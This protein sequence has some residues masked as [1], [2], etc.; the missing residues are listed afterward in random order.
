MEKRRNDHLS[1]TNAQLSNKKNLKGLLSF[2]PYVV[3][4]KIRRWPRKSLVLP[5]G[6][7][8]LDNLY[9]NISNQTRKIARTYH[10]Y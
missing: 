9:L 3:E 7:W 8:K 5:S 1:A 6:F 10:K 2:F 4:G